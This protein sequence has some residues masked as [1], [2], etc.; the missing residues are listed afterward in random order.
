M[1]TLQIRAFYVIAAAAVLGIVGFLAGQEWL[2]AAAALIA[3]VGLI[4]QTLRLEDA[5]SWPRRSEGDSAAAA[6][7]SAKD[8]AVTGTQ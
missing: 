5:L 3:V 1:S 4:L 7:S 8:R 6:S 2:V